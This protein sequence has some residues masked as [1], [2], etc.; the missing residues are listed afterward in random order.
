M[1]KIE[2]AINKG[3][4]FLSKTQKKDGSFL[5]LV[6]TKFDNYSKKNIRVVPAIVP[7][8]IV[9]SSLIKI[10]PRNNVARAIR[11]KA[12]KFLLQEKGSYWS[13]NYWFRKSDWFKRE[14]YPDDLDDTFCALAALCEYKPNLF[15]GEVMAKIVTM[16]TSAEKNEGGPYDMWLVPPEGRKK[17]NETDLVVNSN[18]A[19]FLSLQDIS[20]PKLDSF[21]DKSIEENDYEFPYNRIY[22]GIYFISRF[23]KGQHAGRMIKLIMSKQKRNGKWENPLRT[24][25]AISSLINLANFG[26]MDLKQ[27]KAQIEKG[28][29]YLF[30]SQNKN[31]SWDAASFY[32]Q[33]RTPAKTLYAGSASTTTALCI[34]AL[35]KWQK[36]TAGFAKSVRSVK[37]ASQSKK[38]SSAIVRMVKDGFRECGSE[39][40]EEA[41]KTIRKILAGDKDKQ[42]ALLP[43]FFRM[44]L[45]ENGQNISNELVIRLSAANVFGWIAYTIYD[46]FLDGTGKTNL[47][48]VANVALRSSFQLFSSVLPAETGF[49]EFVKKIFNVIDSANSWEIMKCRSMKSIPNYGDRSQLANKSLGHALGPMAIMFALGYSNNSP[50]VKKLMSFF[51]YFIIARQLNDDAHDWEDD[52]KH[53]HIN[54]VG[55]MIF[56]TK[57][58]T[59]PADELS[60]EF[61]HK[62]IVEVCD[63]IFA[64]TKQARRDLKDLSLIQDKT[65]FE[66]LLA[67]IDAAAEKALKE[68]AETIAFIKTYKGS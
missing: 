36:E 50:E 34:E 23:Y 17:W 38:I 52:L 62:T 42:I 49:G 66:K 54:A 16:L 18:I 22:P 12:A 39:L 29:A 47:L 59:D 37:P 1:N 10:D 30:S 40:Q 24:A 35:N 11:N 56:K 21:I 57:R 55:A 15:N 26:G 13:F 32:F 61:W 63:I 41:R 33:M 45:G 19:F 9:L 64:S 3:L 51:K 8:N 68:R 25:L 6:S 44:S 7:T 4:A 67:P 2:G 48:S 65:I 27:Y 31:G 46:D 43:L 58:P 60:K 5:C 14:P 53:G 28:V 20:L